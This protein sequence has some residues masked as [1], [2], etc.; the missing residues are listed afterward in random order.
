G[1]L[2]PLGVTLPSVAGTITTVDFSSFDEE[3]N[4]SSSVSQ[5]DLFTDN[6]SDADP[7]AN[8][9]GV[10]AE[11]LEG[12]P[13]DDTARRGSAIQREFDANAGDTF[14]FDWTFETDDR[15]NFE[16]NTGNYAFF[17]ED[18]EAPFE[19]QIISI[20]EGDFDDN[21]Q[22]TGNFETTFN[23]NNPTANIGIVQLGNTFNPDTIQESSLQVTNGEIESSEAVPFETSS[24]VGALVLAG[25]IASIAWRRYRRRLKN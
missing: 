4:V 16:G 18:N 14:R 10:D 24:E 15:E 9:L 11:D 3:G 25:G 23:S 17:T 5:A 2:M 1:F 8:F 21:N 19:E 6:S 12:D 22:V 7:L 13:Q 20:S